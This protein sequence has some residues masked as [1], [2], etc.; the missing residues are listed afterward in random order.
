[1]TMA[2]AVETDPR[3][4]DGSRVAFSPC[5][6]Q[7]HLVKGLTSVP[8]D[9]LRHC[10]WMAK[11]CVCVCVCFCSLVLRGALHEYLRV[12]KQLPPR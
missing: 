2:H 6:W 1:M 3:V 11:S 9:A 10:C 4:V 7:T 5:L 8:E 12:P